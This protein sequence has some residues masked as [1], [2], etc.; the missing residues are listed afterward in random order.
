MPT[1]LH[2][3]PI[4]LT[5][6]DDIFREF[7]PEITRYMYPQ[8]TATIAGTIAFIEK[9]IVEK[10]AVRDFQ[11]VILHKDTD[12]FLGCVGLHRLDTKTPDIGIWLKKS[13]H[14]HGYGPEAVRQLK[15]WADQN[16]DYNYLIYPVDK[17][18]LASRKIPES[19][20]GQIAREYEELSQDGRPLNIMEYHIHR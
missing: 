1:R 18:N 10:Q 12:E 13:A 9:S 6:A 19:L 4:N 15:T 2:L 16:L 20:G 14:G 8:P 17:A 5:H 3:A 7:T 11:T